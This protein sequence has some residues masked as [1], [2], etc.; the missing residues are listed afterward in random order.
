MSALE[1]LLA[2]QIRLTGLPSM[3][4]KDNLPEFSA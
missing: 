3:D 1:E 4:R 2:Q